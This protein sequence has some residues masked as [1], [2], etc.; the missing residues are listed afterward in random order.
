MGGLVWLIQ[1]PIRALILLLISY[2]PLGVEMESF[3]VALLSAAV[4]GLLGTLLV[5][6]LKA[7]FALPWALTSLGGLIHTRGGLSHRLVGCRR[8]HRLLGVR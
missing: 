6:P 7:L 8:M 4:I 3:Q 5:L 1:W 2:L